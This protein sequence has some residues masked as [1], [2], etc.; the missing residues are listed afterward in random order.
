[1]AVDCD[2]RERGGEGGWFV[3]V[4]CETQSNLDKAMQLLDSYYK[5]ANAQV[6]RTQEGLPRPTRKWFFETRHVGWIIGGNGENIRSIMRQSGAECVVVD[7]APSNLT[8]ESHV[9]VTANTGA[10][11]DRAVSLLSAHLEEKTGWGGATAPLTVR[12]WFFEDKFA[13]R[14]IGRNGDNI[15]SVQRATGTKCA[16]R[17]KP[18]ELGCGEGAHVV[19]TGDA[20]GVERAV[21]LLATYTP[22]MSKKQK[23]RVRND[24][25]MSKKQKKRVRKDEAPQQGTRSMMPAINGMPLLLGRAPAHSETGAL[26]GRFSLYPSDDEAASAAFQAGERE[27]RGPWEGDSYYHSESDSGGEC[28]FSAAQCEALQEQGIAP[29]DSE[30]GAAVGYL[31]M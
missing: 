11:L 23:K 22:G 14:I 18:A 21:A 24:K 3:T 5:G 25:G 17:S 1:M 26:R 29:W 8:G 10:S 15:L 30:A 20:A 12:K 13:G 7:H 9:L 6:S 27:R 16:V 19:V 31:F 2:G 28:G 4:S